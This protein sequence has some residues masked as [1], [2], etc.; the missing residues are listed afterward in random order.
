MSEYDGKTQQQLEGALT[1]LHGQIKALKSKKRAVGLAL[2]KHSSAAEVE[3]KFAMLSEQDRAHMRTL[4]GPSGIAS[5]EK[6][7]APG[8][9]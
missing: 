2:S 9:A 4:L 1:D 8:G 5:G 6:V 3:A 7:G